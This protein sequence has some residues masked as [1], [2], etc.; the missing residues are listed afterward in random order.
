M[1]RPM[2]LVAIQLED[3]ALREPEVVHHR[4]ARRKF[5]RGVPDRPGQRLLGHEDLEP[6]LE[7]AVAAAL[8]EPVRGEDLPDRPGAR[9][10]RMSVE[11]GGQRAGAREALN[12]GLVDRKLQPCRAEYR[13]EIEQGSRDRRGRDRVDHL[14]LIR[15]KVRPMEPEL[16]SRPERSG[17]GDVDGSGTPTHDATVGG[18]GDEAERGIIS[19]G[20]DGGHPR[21][22]PTSGSMPDGVDARVLPD[23]MPGSDPAIDLVTGQPRRQELATG[24]PPVLGGSDGSDQLIRMPAAGSFV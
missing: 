12:L 24:D 18:S 16:R 19:G 7:L 6:V 17:A 21:R 9:P 14:D 1:R 2:V 20:E 10:A 22:R 8:T 11:Q 15:S 13:R 3:D 23:Q 4:R 5:N